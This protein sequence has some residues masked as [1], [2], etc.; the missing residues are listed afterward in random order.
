MVGLLGAQ[1]FND[2]EL[3]NIV[4]RRNV[5]VSRAAKPRRGSMIQCLIPKA[6]RRMVECQGGRAGLGRVIV[7]VVLAL[8]LDASSSYGAADH[9]GLAV[10]DSSGAILFKLAFF[11]GSF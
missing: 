1:I 3:S 4:Q 10:A 11:G 8:A 5:E 2:V 9:A 7:L 6:V